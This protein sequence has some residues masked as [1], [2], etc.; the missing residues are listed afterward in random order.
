MFILANRKYYVIYTSGND[1][2][3]SGPYTFRDSVMQRDYLQLIFKNAC[4]V[5]KVVDEEGNLVNGNS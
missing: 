1:L 2:Q 5:Q 3:L 4:I